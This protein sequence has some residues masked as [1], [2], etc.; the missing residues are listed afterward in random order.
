MMKQLLLNQWKQ[1]GRG[2]AL[3]GMLL[4]TAMTLLPQRA[5]ADDDNTSPTLTSVISSVTGS[6]GNYELSSEGPEWEVV[7]V[8]AGATL[9]TLSDDNGVLL[10]KDAS[11]TTPLSIT[12]R[13]KSKM[14]A[15]YYYNASTFSNT[16]RILSPQMMKNSTFCNVAVVLKGGNT[17]IIDML[18]KGSKYPIGYN[19]ITS[20]TQFSDGNGSSQGPVLIDNEYLTMTLT[21]TGESENENVTSF[22]FKQI[23]LYNAYLGSNAYSHFTASDTSTNTC[24]SSTGNHWISSVPLDFN[25]ANSDPPGMGFFYQ[26]ADS[27]EKTHYEDV[28]VTSDFM[29]EGQLSGIRV[30]GS[31]MYDDNTKVELTKVEKESSEGTYTDISFTDYKMEP[32][33]YPI[34]GAHFDNA[35]TVNGRLR[36]TF[37]VTNKN[38]LDYVTL[39]DIVLFGITATAASSQ[40]GSGLKIGGETYVEDSQ[41]ITFNEETN[42]LTLNGA[43]VEGGVE[44]SNSENLTIA[45]EGES[46]INGAI[47]CTTATNSPNITFTTDKDNPGTLTVTTTDGS[48]VISGFGNYATPTFG[49]GLEFTEVETDASGNVTSAT[50]SVPSL[51]VAGVAVTSKNAANIF[52]QD[53]VNSGKVSFDATTST[54]TLNGAVFANF[55]ETDIKSSLDQLTIKF[56]GYNMIGAVVSTK[57]TAT[58]TIAL[59][60]DAE[61]GSVLYFGMKGD[62]PWSGFSGNPTLGEN[63]VYLPNSDS[64]FI[65]KLPSPS[66]SYDKDTHL[67]LNAGDGYGTTFYAIDYVDASLTDVTATRFD[68]SSNDPVTLAGPCTVTA[69]ATYTDVLGNTATSENATGVLVGFANSEISIVKGET[70]PLPALVPA[71]DGIKIGD[72]SPDGVVVSMEENDGE[73][74]IK[75]DQYG[76]ATVTGY[77]FDSSDI[78][79]VGILNENG[80]SLTVTVVPPAPTIGYDETKTYLSSDKVELE[81]PE[82]LTDDRNAVLY[83]SWTEGGDGSEYNSESKIELTAGEGT[84]Y[85]WVRYNGETTVYSAKVSQTFTVKADINDAYVKMGETSATYTGE[86]ITPSFTVYDSEKTMQQVSAEEYTLSY[87]KVGTQTEP[88]DAIVEVGTYVVNITGTGSTY[89]GTKTVTREFTVGQAAN[90]YT[91]TPAAVAE[92]AYTGEAQELVTAGVAAFGDIQYKLGDTGEWG[93]DIPTG[94]AVGSYVVYYKVDGTDNYAGIEPASI[95]VTIAAAAATITAESEQSATYSGEA[96]EI[97]ATVDKG[98]IAITYYNSEDEREKG[99]NALETAPVNAGTYYARVSQTSDSYTANP[100]DVTFTIGQKT[101]TEDMVTLSAESFE[102]NGETQKPEVTVS[103]KMTVKEVETEIITADDYTITNEGGSAVGTYTVTVTGKGN[104]TGEVTKTFEI[105]RR[106][107]SADELGIS[108]E[109]NYGSYY[110]ATEDLALPEG[111]SAYIV[112]GITGA[113]ATLTAISYIPKATPVIVSQSGDS[114]EATDA[115]TGGNMMQHADGDVTVASIN[116]TVYGLYN[117]VLMRVSRTIPAGKNYLVVTG[118]AGAPK[119]TFV[120]DKGQ[121][122]GSA[123]AIGTIEAS[124]ADHDAW[125]TLDGR[126]LQQKPSQKGLYIRNGQ[127]VVVNK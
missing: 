70:A 90:E 60:A 68:A 123:T 26:D 66:I 124:E 64:R 122:E 115:A 92:L 4:A 15:Y 21:A 99:S 101:L 117:N 44:W 80:V 107:V 67:T 114:G 65:K 31:L 91:T 59:A 48:N 112:S 106:T 81:K 54:L 35:V 28:T 125:Y 120:V 40:T 12:L 93:T 75:A 19:D 71:V 127:K 5:W 38:N 29:C 43:T 46:T 61:E 34:M 79:T 8:S 16:V 51:T 118:A 113:A 49:N 84:L 109:G 95:E 102:Y 74:V 97:A 58:L 100:V 78:P 62:Y 119:L 41:T 39:R 72:V 83:Y 104:Y 82:S 121:G 76:A 126:R 94:I 20:Y 103:D 18:T 86:A 37:N 52:S 56:S 110:H 85:A 53:E 17:T 88:V 6:D 63:M 10:S 77:P 24:S 87:Q 105:S 30:F 7:S 23:D 73:L 13:T 42:T 27:Q 36:L 25:A 9:T 69:Y 3:L 116:G 89:G 11:E 33:D 98:E 50:V 111:Y 108:G 2:F 57:E 47:T 45:L 32:S 22:S 1:S 96:H 14:S 55:G